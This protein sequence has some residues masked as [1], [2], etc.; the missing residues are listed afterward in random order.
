MKVIL[1][2]HAS[3]RSLR[4]RMGEKKDNSLPKRMS[5]DKIRGMRSEHNE[6][7]EV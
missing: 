7:S 3:I 6:G 2:A 5:N 1:N 4:L